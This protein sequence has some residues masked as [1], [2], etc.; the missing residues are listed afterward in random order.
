MATARRLAESTPAE[1]NRVV[2]LLRVASILVVVFGHWLV[3]VVTFEGGALEAGNL[4]DLSGW[5]HP[6]T[7]VLQVMPVFFFV[8]G[9]S[10]ALSW[11]S[12][13]R[14]GETY[15]GWLRSRLRRLTLPIVPLLAVWGIGG[16]LALQGGF[17][18][19]TLSLAS[20]V[21][22][23]PTWFLA[24]YVVIVG[25]A[26]VTLALWDKL[27]L[28]SIAA[29]VALAVIADV[30]SINFDLLA[31]GF[32]NY[33]FVWG[34]IHQLG[35]A[36]LDG[37]FGGLARRLLTAGVGLTVLLALVTVG[38]YAVAMVGGGGDGVANTFPPR[39]TLIFL[40]LFQVGLILAAEPLLERMTRKVGVWIGIAAVSA[41][42]MTL[43]LWHLTAMIVVI[44]VGA[45]LGGVGLGIEPVSPV[46]WLTR[47]VWIGILTFTTLAL[48]LVFSRFER[49]RV[50][51]RPEPRSS[52]PVLAVLMICVGLGLLA[53]GGIADLEG[54]N[55]WILTLPVIGMVLGGVIG[56][57]PTRDQV[58]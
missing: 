6:L 22:M 15:G 35:Y 23:V 38:P 52:R 31:I 4:L 42:I 58:R 11:R 53:S 34:A 20:Q 46:W 8:G 25:L 12:A 9:F 41:Q 24:V 10:N 7:W 28:W 17:D 14:R 1:R 3:A 21:A 55:G 18:P 29:G 5:T 47:P 32:L 43:Y 16:W 13:Q 19:A 51:L 27:G 57:T 33:V 54:L 45:G 39:V 50:D 40:G 37:K 48:S 49:P 30:V 2:D 26:P 56:A 36:W 44:G